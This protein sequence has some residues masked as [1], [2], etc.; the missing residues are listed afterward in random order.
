MLIDNSKNKINNTIYVNKI[1]L[2]SS[3]YYDN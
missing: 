3:Y 2:I 1:N